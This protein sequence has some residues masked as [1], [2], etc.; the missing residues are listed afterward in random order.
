LWRKRYQVDPPFD[1][2][3]RGG[4][5]N[6]RETFRGSLFSSETT[7][8]GVVVDA[9]ASV[10]DRFAA[11]YQALVERGYR[12]V[13][14]TIPP[15]GLVLHRP[16][17][18]VPTVGIWIMPNNREAGALEEFV[19]AL[20]RPGDQ[21]WAHASQVVAQMPQELRVYPEQHRTKAQLYTWLAWQAEPGVRLPLALD[22]S[23]LSSEA[24]TAQAFLSWVTRLF[25]DDVEDAG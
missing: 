5:V 16:T 15:D 11:F 8:L 22:R 21:L 17:R 10:P 19:A 14:K 18:T 23:M 9:D 2:D 25:V 20:V 13:P 6:V 3:V 24:E 7:R 12:P 1:F 4:L